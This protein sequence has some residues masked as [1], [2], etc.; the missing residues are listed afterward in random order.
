MKTDCQ[1]RFKPFGAIAVAMLLV[2]GIAVGAGNAAQTGKPSIRS[3]SEINYPPFCIVDAQG[4]AGGFSVEL[5]RAALTAMGREVTF[6]TGPWASVK[7]WLERGKV[8]ALPLVGRTPEREDLFDFTFPYM[9]IHGAI[10]VRENTKNINDLGDL[11]GRQVTVMKGDNAEEFLRREA[12]GIDIHTTATFDEALRELSK[13]RYDAVVIQRLVALRLIQEAGLTNLRIVNK[14]IEDYRQDFCFAVREGDRE[15]LAL[16]NEGLALIMADGTYRHLH[17]KW[18]AALQ[19]PSHRRIVVGGDHNFPPYEYLNEKERPAGYNVELTRAIARE[20]GLDIEIRLGPWVKIRE[21]LARGDIDAVQGMFYSLERDMKFDFSQAH[22]LNHCVSVVRRGEGDPPATVGELADRRIVVQRGDIMHDFALENGLGKEVSVVDAQEVALRELAEGKH[23]CALVSRVTAL[24]CIKKEGLTNLVVGK[25]PLISTEYCYAVPNNHRPL[26]AQF[27]E[28]LKVLEESGEYRRIYEKWMGIYREKE[29]SFISLLRYVAMVFVPLILILLAIS[30]WSWFL[31]RQVA[32]RT[33]EL[34]AVSQRHQA[35]LAAVPDIIMEVDSHK[36]YTWANQA[37]L[38]FF[39]DDVIG[40]EAEYYFI[41]EQ[42]TYDT[43]R[44][45]FDGDEGVIYVESW[46]K[47]KDGQDRLLAWWTRVLKDKTGRVSGVLSTA[48][49]ITELKRAEEELLKSETLFRMLVENMH[50]SISLFDLDFHYIYQSPSEVRVTGYTAEEIIAIPVQEQMTP[51]SYRLVKEAM[52][53]ELALEFSGEPVDLQRF[54]TLELELYHKERGTVWGELTAVFQ[55]D[56]EGKPT[57]ILMISR[58]ITDRR[59]AEEK[60][61]ESEERYRTILES[62]ENGYWEIDLEGKFTFF[63]DAMLRLTNTSP[64]ELMGMSYRDYSAPQA[65]KTL[66]RIFN[67]VYRTGKPSESADHEATLHGHT[68]IFEISVSLMRDEKGNPIGFRGITRDVTQSREIEAKLRESEERYRMIVERMSDIVWI[69]DMNLRT[70]FVTPSLQTMLGFTPEER[71]LQ[72]IEEQLT[73]DSLSY[74]SNLLAEELAVEEGGEVNPNR[75]INVELECYHKDGSTRWVETSIAWIRGGQGTVTGLLGVFRDITTRR[76]AEEQL[77][78]TLER[79]RKSVGV[80]IQAMVSAVETRDPYT[81]GHQLRSADLTCAIATEMG[82]DQERIDA[83][84]MAASIHDI[85][86]LSIPAEILSKPTQLSDIEFSLIKEHSKKG[87]EILKNVETDWPL[88]EII[89][90]HHERM[91]GSGY[92]RNLKGDE[93]IMEA[94]IMAVAD[95]V[96]SMASH[97][98]YRVALGVEAALE[99]IENNKGTLY[100]RDVVDVCLRL[101]REK[102]YQLPMPIQQ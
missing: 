5:M 54:R 97:R 89:Y 57:G 48:R 52:T 40:R 45:L 70:T 19:L 43:V 30:L 7:S 6:R 18:F 83:I 32:S 82:F 84:S 12:R 22:I 96:E 67:Q 36:V 94:R 27:S 58:D 93:I 90:Q 9:S 39:G 14:P 86:K 79:L 33:A 98:P 42:D 49:D 31:R 2:F 29:L 62:I 3:A 73:P 38:D 44:P 80:T 75:S 85:G 55:R 63:N 34:A 46:Q 8:Q 51:E 99:E 47:R 59:R 15:T 37:G 4:R 16:L 56:E 64:E 77:Q 25:K 26:L 87:Y 13:G 50:D 23:D 1:V 69:T 20:M 68:L 71:M 35:I 78:G 100:D 61:R 76:Q 91:D 21:A 101:F 10:V 41:G 74:A 11:K 88:A 53:E 17:S 72:P 28:G 95:V 24:Y 66:Y 102:G 65:Q 60:L 81:A 92:P